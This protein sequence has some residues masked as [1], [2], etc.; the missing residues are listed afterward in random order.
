[1]C[2]PALALGVIPWLFMSGAALADPGD[3]C[4][5]DD[6]CGSEMTCYCDQSDHTCHSGCQSDLACRMMWHREDTHCDTSPG[7]HICV[8]CL[9]DADCPAGETCG[10]DS[11]G[12]VGCLK[13]A[14]TGSNTSDDSGDDDSQAPSG[15]DSTD[16]S[17][18]ASPGDDNDG[19]QSPGGDDSAD[20]NAAPSSPDDDDDAPG[21]NAF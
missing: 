15:D 21:S 19:S 8:D 11:R 12:M 4:N 13:S 10:Q 6:D 5:T 1:M 17:S 16:D 9:S 18:S 7:R 14:T 20:D 2:L 3:Q